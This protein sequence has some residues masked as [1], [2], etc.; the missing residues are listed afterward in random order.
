M[1]ADFIDSYMEFTSDISSPRIFRRWAAIGAVAGALERRCWIR[2]RKG[3]IFPNLITLLVSS[4][5]IGKT[6]AI[7][8]VEKLWRDTK[9]LHVAPKSITK[10]SLVDNLQASEQIKIGAQGYAFHSLQLSLPEFGTFLTAHDLEML[11]TINDIYDC[12]PVYSERRRYFNE[13]KELSI[14]NPQINIL[15]GIQPGFM[16]KTLPEEAWSMGFTSRVIMVY[17]GNAEE[18]GSLWGAETDKSLAPMQSIIN[19]FCDLYG[20]FKWTDE[21]KS[22]MDLWYQ[23]GLKP[24]PDHSKLANYL[25]RRILHALKLCMVSGVSRTHKLEIDTEDVVRALKWLID[26][27]KKMSDIF[28]EMVQKSDNDIIIE[29]HFAMWR[30]WIGNENKPIHQSMIYNFLSERSPVEKIPR[31]IEVAERANFI[32]RYEISN[33]HWI[34]IPKNKHGIE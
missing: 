4:P 22:A 19:G 18:Q 13:G 34:P 6:E 3:A 28:R 17:A 24:V 5:G 27:E 11:S 15:A 14:E 8:P 12:P 25:P 29:L 16:A 31:L 9:K 10:A 33:E 20:Q 30:I 2:T 32:K 7:K 23:G 21:A 1:P 26:A